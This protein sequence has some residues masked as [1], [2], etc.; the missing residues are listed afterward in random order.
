MAQQGVE[1]VGVDKHN[2]ART[3]RMALYGGAV[4]GPAAT[5]WFKFL[6]EKIKF[7][8]PNLTIAARVLTD[9]CVFASTNM[10]VFLS[11]MAIM[12]GSSPKEKLES[13][14]TTALKKNW[15]VWP[16]VQAVNFKF[17]PLEHR[18]LVVNIVSLATD[19]IL[20]IDEAGV[21]SRLSSIIVRHNSGSQAEMVARGLIT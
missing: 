3:G 18:V 7:Q 11:S 10:F 21:A 20:A 5:T 1:R 15:M 8:N 4:F 16:A 9:Q 6:Q 12:E 2:Y 19:S 17:V 13:T 14:Y